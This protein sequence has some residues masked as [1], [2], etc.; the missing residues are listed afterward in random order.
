MFIVVV[1]QVIGLGMILILFPL[2]C[3]FP[4]L[5]NK[6]LSLLRLERKYYQAGVR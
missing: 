1:S 3:I 6:Y 4:V 5:Y 2:V